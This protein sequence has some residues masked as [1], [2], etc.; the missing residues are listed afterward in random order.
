[1]KVF[2]EFV[3]R[4]GGSIVNFSVDEEEAYKREW[5]EKVVPPDKR[6]LAEKCHCFNRNDEYGVIHGFLWHVFSYKILDCL[7]GEKAK[8]S[9]NNTVKKDA[10][11]LVGFTQTDVETSR[12]RDISFLTADVLDSLADVII[13]D[14]GFKWTYVKTHEKQCGP[15]YHYIRTVET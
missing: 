14:S 2:N 1:M 11:L 15:Y 13:T 4:N 5:F 9:F 12:L 3:L 10:V 8:N 6:E 7:V